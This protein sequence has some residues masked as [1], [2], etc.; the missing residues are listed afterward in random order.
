M[1]YFFFYWENVSTLDS[2]DRSIDR[3][4]ESINICTTPSFSPS[5]IIII[6]IILLKGNET[7]EFFQIHLPQGGIVGWGGV[8]DTPE[9]SSD[10]K[11]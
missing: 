2:I 5:V 11:N 10:E 1:K 8:S 7:E 9:V 3:F 4:I 6:I